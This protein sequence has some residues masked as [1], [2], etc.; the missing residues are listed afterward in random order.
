MKGSQDSLEPGDLGL[1]ILHDVGVEVVSVDSA[2]VPDAV[3]EP[4]IDQFNAEPLHQQQDVVVDRRD[5]SRDGNVEGNR[6]AVILWHVGG[7]RVSAH[8]V[9]GFE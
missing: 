6:A 4:G 9:L 2:A 7:H 5:E 3:I 1:Q 8:S